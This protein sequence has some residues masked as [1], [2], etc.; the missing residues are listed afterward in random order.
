MGAAHQSCNL[1]RPAPR[2]RY[3]RFA[4]NRSPSAVSFFW[5]KHM[6]SI[7]IALSLGLVLA[8]SA[9]ALAKE[10]KKAETKTVS[11][12]SGCSECDGVVKTGHNI[13][14]TDKDGTRW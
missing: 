5:E 2:A 6:K 9:G 12:K 10:D 11:G 8:F 7:L 1:S 3:T 4:A 13:M 14:L